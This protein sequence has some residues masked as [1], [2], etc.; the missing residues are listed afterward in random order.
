MLFS[1]SG[2]QDGYSHKSGYNVL[3]CGPT[4]G[5]DM[6]VHQLPYSLPVEVER[7]PDVSKSFTTVN[8]FQLAVYSF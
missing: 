2:A 1:G 8:V 7:A 5:R 3:I 6:W 4:S